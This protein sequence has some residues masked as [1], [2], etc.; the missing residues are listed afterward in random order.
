V[1]RQQVAYL[2]Q[3]RAKF[4]EEIRRQLAACKSRLIVQIEQQFSEM[5]RQ[6]G[7]QLQQQETL[8]QQESKGLAVQIEGKEQELYV[9]WKGL[10]E[11]GSSLRSL[12]SY[13]QKNYS[14]QHDEVRTK[15]EQQ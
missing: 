12:I 2:L 3:V 15:I 8:N 11:G 6:I 9:L 4:E 5:E 14:G 13:F 1:Q 10:S 7:Q